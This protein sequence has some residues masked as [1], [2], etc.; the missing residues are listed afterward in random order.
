MISLKGNDVFQQ[1]YDFQKTDPSLALLLLNLNQI[2]K[3]YSKILF[4][5][6]RNMTLQ[7]HDVM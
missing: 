5:P 2:L 4:L 1:K 7:N 3:N 6:I